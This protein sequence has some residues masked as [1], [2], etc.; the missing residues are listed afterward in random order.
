MRLPQL[1]MLLPPLPF[2]GSGFTALSRVFG[3]SPY[4]SASTNLSRFTLHGVFSKR[5]PK[6]SYRKQYHRGEEIKGLNKTLNTNND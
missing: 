5:H 1:L 3:I 4:D 6:A 2:S